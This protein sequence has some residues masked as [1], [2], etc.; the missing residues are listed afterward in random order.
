MESPLTFSHL[1]MARE[2]LFEFGLDGAFGRGA[3][4]AGDINERADELG[5]GLE[6]SVVGVVGPGVVDGHAGFPEAEIFRLGDA[7]SSA[8]IGEVI[9]AGVG[10]SAS[11]DGLGENC[12]GVSKSPGTEGFENGIDV[13]RE[14]GWGPGGRGRCSKEARESAVDVVPL[15]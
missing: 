5:S 15:G 4:L 14:I 12:S 1:P 13:E 9:A 11:G 6:L 8:V 2:V 3:A 10:A 7:C